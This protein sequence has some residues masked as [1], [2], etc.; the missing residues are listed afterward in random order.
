MNRNSSQKPILRLFPGSAATTSLHGLYLDEP[1]R[2]AGTPTRPFVYASFIASLDGRISLPDP[3]TKVRRPPRAITNP[4][5][6]RL[7]QELAASADVLVTSGRYIRDLAAGVAQAG[8]PV[9]EKSEFADLHE[10]RRARGLTPQPAVAI[11][12]DSL[13]LPIPEALLD[14][15]R[16]IY[17]ATG[18]ATDT[19]PIKTLTA[20]GVR[21]L[22]CGGGT[23]IEGR[24]LVAV[25]AREGFGN[26]DMT[27]GAELLN[28]LLA[29]RAFDR[30]YLTQAC[31]ILGGLSFDTLLKGRPLDPPADFKLRSLCYDA[32]DGSAVEQLFVVFDY[33]E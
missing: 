30:L 21:V 23:R 18:T 32:G 20:R 19:S 17:V 10:W 11:V 13:D 24:A 26:I 8:L 14:S 6:W 29:D 12:T 28:T 9:S 3:E 4:R 27:A 15:G 2:P 16:P 31:R 33:W 7:V 22:R 1:L 25:L 5:D